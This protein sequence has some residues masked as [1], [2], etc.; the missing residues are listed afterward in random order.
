MTAEVPPDAFSAIP[1]AP[2]GMGHIYIIQFSTGSV[3]VGKTADLRRRIGEHRRASHPFG[4]AMTTIWYS[5][6]F[7]DWHAVER[8][9]IARATETC[10]TRRRHEYFTGVSVEELADFIW[11]TAPETEGRF[12]PECLNADVPTVEVAAG[13]SR[14]R[15]SRSKAVGMAVATA[16][17]V[18]FSVLFMDYQLLRADVPIYTALVPV[19]I[20]VVVGVLA[21]ESGASR[22]LRIMEWV[23]GLGVAGW[24]A[25]WSAEY[26]RAAGARDPWGAAVGCTLACAVGPIMLAVHLSTSAALRR[27]DSTAL[28]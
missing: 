2:A 28:A 23:L 14:M 18:T 4:A 12:E 15:R 16:S 20:A 25:L 5:R 17:E 10:A 8:R 11:E 24:F 13:P 26:S 22:R 3:K 9:L 1:P 7:E 6:P 19:A 21:L 27:S